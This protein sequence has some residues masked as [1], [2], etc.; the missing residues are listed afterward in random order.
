MIIIPK[1]A[2]G[3]VENYIISLHLVE[4][5]MEKVYQL[6]RTAGFNDYY[7]GSLKTGAKK[8]GRLE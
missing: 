7:Y 8:L 3:V 6:M 1:A 5:D 4:Y 2:F